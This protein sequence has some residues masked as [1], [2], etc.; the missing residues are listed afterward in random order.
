MNARFLFRAFKARFRDQRAEIQAVLSSLQSGDRAVDVG[1][2][3]GSYLYWLRKAV[4]QQGKVFAF[5]PQPELKRYLEIICAA[6][7]WGNVQVY[8]LAV[9]DMVGRATLNVPSGGVSPGASLEQAVASSAPGR[10]YECA[11][12]TLDRC[13]K[14]AGPI[15]F[16]KVDAEG[17][18]LQV[19]RGAADILSR[20]TPVILFECEARHLSN[21][22]MRDVF[23]YLQNLGYDGEFFS[24]L[25]LRPLKEFDPVV[26]QRSDSERFWDAP[27]Y[28]NNFL[29]KSRRPAC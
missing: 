14:N 24:P 1:A 11:V 25:G 27:D 6:S 26:H 21:H 4:G 28:C 12:D 13:L 17:H 15:N 23:S 3:K 20:F 5:E 8:D 2:Y 16:L 29:F 10:G 22:T 9:S 7:K 19:F 18:E